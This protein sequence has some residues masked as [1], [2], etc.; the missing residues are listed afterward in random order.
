MK[1]TSVFANSIMAIGLISCHRHEESEVEAQIAR[2]GLDYC[3]VKRRAAVDPSALRQFL[4]CSTLTDGAGSED[5][6]EDLDR[7][8]EKCGE[9]RLLEALDSVTSEVRRSVLGDFAYNAGYREVNWVWSRFSVTY[10][11]LARRISSERW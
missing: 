10:P 5:Y 11:V 4:R 6:C 8:L 9:F 2:H 3:S 1:F 7:L